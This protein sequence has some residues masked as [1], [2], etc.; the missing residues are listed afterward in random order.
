[1]THAHRHSR[2]SR[3]DGRAKVTGDGEVRRRVH[4]AGPRLRL[5]RVQR[6]RQ[7]QDH[8]DRRERGAERCPACSRSSRTRTA[9]ALAG[10]TRSYRD[11]IA[12]PG[13]PFRPLYDAEIQFSGQ[14]VA[15]VVAETSSCARS[16]RR[17]CA[18]EYERRAARHRPAG[19]RCDERYEPQEARR[20]QAAA[21]SRAA[22]PTRPSPRPPCRSTREYHVPVEHHNPMEMFATTVVWDE[23]RHAH[24]LR[25]DPGRRRTSSDYLCNVFGFQETRCASSR[26]YVGGAFGSGLR[27]QYQVVPGGDGGARAEALGAGGADPPADVHPR[28]PARRRCSA[29]RSGRRRRRAAGDHPRGDRPRPRGS[30]TTARTSSTG[31]AC[32]TSA[33]TS[34]LDYKVAQLDLPTPCDMRAPGAAIGRVRARMRDGRAGLRC[35]HR[36]ARAA[37]EELRRAR[38]RTTTSRSRARSCARATRKARSGSAGR[39]RSPAPRSMRDGHELVGWGMATGVWEPDACRRRAAAVLTADG[40]LDG[41]AARPPTSAPAPTRS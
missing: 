2:V 1:M 20:H 24:R 8:R 41:R 11:E 19:E 13:S 27:P 33:T 32:S 28:P 39:R 5:R 16:P 6:H 34:R 12:P 18:I 10:S 23:R 29:S 40:K 35:G 38:T 7:G 26:P 37:A 17:W 36:S 14:P 9:R 4:V 30:R 22:T 31:R 25:Q 15:L 3:V 21:R